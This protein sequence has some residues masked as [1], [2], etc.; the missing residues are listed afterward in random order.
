MTRKRGACVPAR[1]HRTA[2]PGAKVIRHDNRYDPALT[3]AARRRQPGGKPVAEIRNYTMNF[4]PQH[5]AARVLRLV[6]EMTA[7]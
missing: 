1:E 7:K 6:L 3:N 2:H 5:P 4:G